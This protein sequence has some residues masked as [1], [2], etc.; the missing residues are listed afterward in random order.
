[1]STHDFPANQRQAE[2]ESLRKDTGSGRQPDDDQ[3]VSELHGALEAH[4]KRLIVTATYTTRGH[5]SESQRYHKWDHWLGLPATITSAL[6]SAGAGIAAL[7]ESQRLLTFALAALATLT[8]AARAFLKYGDL[9]ESHGVKANQYLTLLNEARFLYEVDLRDHRRSNN[10]LSDQLRE[11]W[12][13]YNA[14]NESPPY[15]I[16][17]GSYSHAKHGIEAGE[18]TFENDL[19]W[20]DLDR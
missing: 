6:L 14:L 11:L 8:S 13:R 16:S 19:L 3:T 17:S 2:A 4:T 12:K 15:R 5:F 9:A 18:A 1:M 7:L 20:K 10:E